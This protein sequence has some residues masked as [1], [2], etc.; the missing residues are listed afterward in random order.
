MKV[1]IVDT[2]YGGY[3]VAK[4]DNYKNVIFIPHCVEGDIL[5]VDIIKEKKN[6]SFAYIKNILEPS[7]YRV[8]PE[9]KYA[10][11]CGGCSFNHI[12]YNKQIDIK[13]SILS[14]A[15]R[16]INYNNTINTIVQ[17]ENS[18]D[19]RLRVNIL[20][21]EGR[22]GFYKFNT[23]EFVEIDDCVVLKKS[24]LEKIKQFVYKNNISANIYI[25]END[26]NESLAFVDLLKNTNIIDYTFF[27]GCTIKYKNNIKNYGLENILYTTKYGEISISN[28]SFFQSNRFLLDVFQDESIKYIEN[29]NSVVELYAGSGFFTSAIYSKTNNVVS[30]EISNSAKLGRKYNIIKE[31]AFDTLRKCSDYI[32]VLFLD[33][34]RAGLDKNVIEE[35]L[36][37]KPKSIIYVSCNPMT[38][39]RDIE[40]LKHYY[41]LV[42]LKLIDMFVDTYHIEIIS[43]LSII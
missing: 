24:L 9:C 7:T 40:R 19:Y 30:S 20:A 17:K 10:S 23:N 5:D 3:G 18:K 36:R 26:K 42:D 35:I 28:E 31:S 11:V 38:F 39:S 33:P 13:K 21:R 22:I 27:D 15:I 6:I 1:R 43:F 12:D 8:V 34:P 37:I 2:A 25:I 41:N 4:L 32:D 29:N 16:N 14:S